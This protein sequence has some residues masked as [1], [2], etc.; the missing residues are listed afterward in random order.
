MCV[1]KFNVLLIHRSVHILF[2]SISFYPATRRDIHQRQSLFEQRKKASERVSECKAM[3]QIMK[4]SDEKILEAV[5]TRERRTSES[6]S[7]IR[8]TVVLERNIYFGTH[9]AEEEA[10][11]DLRRDVSMPNI[12]LEGTRK[13]RANS[14]HVD[15]N[16]R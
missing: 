2:P 13:K 9:L 6:H 16:S 5:S 1:L 12:Y 14:I 15:R 10:S 4:G 8:Y 7:K 3:S 11:R